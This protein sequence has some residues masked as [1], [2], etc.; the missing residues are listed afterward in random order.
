MNAINL[1]VTVCAVASPAAA[2]ERYR[3]DRIGWERWL[4]LRAS[5]LGD[6]ESFQITP[7]QERQDRLRDS[8]PGVFGLLIRMTVNHGGR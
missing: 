6:V 2:H 4:G 3:R 5:E 7:T 1:I 8:T